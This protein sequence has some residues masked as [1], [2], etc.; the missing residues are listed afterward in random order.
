VETWF[1][2]R[3][4]FYYGALLCID[5]AQRGF[6]VKLGTLVH[7]A[8]ERFHTDVRD[9]R[10]V[11]ADSHFGWAATLY[12]RAQE[13][14]ASETFEPFGSTLELAAAMRSVKRLLAR[15]ACELEASAR[16]SEG[17]FTVVA[18][19]EG[20]SFEVRASLSAERSIVST[21]GRT[22]RSCSST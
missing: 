13:I 5:G 11:G 21:D 14:V 18:S 12:A 22:G 7:R 16:A 19:E 1:A 15:Y 8:I 4:K 20:V 17:G 3:R 9:F 6:S 2:C 10:S